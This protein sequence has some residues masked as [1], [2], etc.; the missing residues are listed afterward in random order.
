MDKYALDRTEKQKG[1]LIEAY[2]DIIQ[3]LTEFKYQLE[4]DLYIDKEAPIEVFFQVIH[5]VVSRKEGL[6]RTKMQLDEIA[7]S[8]TK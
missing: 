5:Q 6:V 8:N 1:Y 3:T 2:E 4:N 7:E